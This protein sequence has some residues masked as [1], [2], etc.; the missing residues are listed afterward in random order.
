MV[1][2]E[3]NKIPV[4]ALLE[5]DEKMTELNLSS[6]YVGVTGVYVLAGCLKVFFFRAYSWNIP[7]CYRAL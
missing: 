2:E 6:K 4:K 3:F 1:L 7:L 5:N